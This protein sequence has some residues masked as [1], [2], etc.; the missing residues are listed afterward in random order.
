M[1]HQL[2]D[3]LNQYLHG[4]QRDFLLK[5]GYCHGLTLLWLHVVSQKN[6]SWFYQTVE[7]VLSC[8]S[9]FSKIENDVE[10]F[11]AYIEWLQHSSQYEYSVNQ[12]DVS[13]LTGLN[14][15]GSLSF[16]MRPEDID[17]LIK[18]AVQE[19][20]YICLS[21]HDHSVGVVWRDGV[22]YLFDVNFSDLKPKAFR[23]N[24]DLKFALVK[25]LYR[26]DYLPDVR[27]PLHV[28]VLSCQ[29][30]AD[31]K[32]NEMYEYLIEGRDDLDAP[33]FERMTNL[34]LAC[35]RGDEKMVQDLLRRNVD[36]NKRVK[37]WTPLHVAAAHGHQSI[38]K[39]LIKFGA[40]TG[41]K[42]DHG[43]TPKDLADAYHHD[44]VVKLLSSA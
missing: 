31:N 28:N 5:G 24:D 12:L 19:N 6:E 1:S 9:D 14:L 25:S 44:D 7:S 11:I 18:C 17:L 36:L 35:E 27:L 34:Y 43:L 39:A 2:I 26:R 10:K 3:Q 8:K 22:V 20:K 37:T 41:A 23:D 15:D 16:L 13:E 33:G 42:T 21:S 29:P 30:R 4:K 40:I 38:V 32:V